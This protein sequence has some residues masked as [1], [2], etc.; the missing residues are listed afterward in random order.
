MDDVIAK[1][2]DDVM[3]HVVGDAIGLIDAELSAKRPKARWM[4]EKAI[5]LVVGKR[6]A[7]RLNARLR[8]NERTSDIFIANNRYLI[9]LLQKT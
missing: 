8:G 4:L 3:E 1:A 9:T 5:G 2:L 7:R 6:K